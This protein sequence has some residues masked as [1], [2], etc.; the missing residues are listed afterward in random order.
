MDKLNKEFKKF[1]EK[2]IGE[3]LNDN[4]IDISQYQ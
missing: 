2:I 4:D 1:V 3:D